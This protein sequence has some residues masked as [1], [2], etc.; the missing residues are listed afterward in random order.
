[1]LSLTYE[2]KMAHKLHLTQATSTSILG[3]LSLCFFLFKLW[4]RLREMQT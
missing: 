1:M 3:L 2:L 4:D